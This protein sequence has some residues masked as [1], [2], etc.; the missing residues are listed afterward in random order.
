MLRNTDIRNDDAL[1]FSSFSIEINVFET[2]FYYLSHAYLCINVLSR[3]HFAAYVSILICMLTPHLPIS[4]LLFV[5]YTMRILMS[6][7]ANRVFLGSEFLCVNLFTNTMYLSS[8]FQT[9]RLP[10]R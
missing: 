4:V 8:V 1:N 3:N 9:V 6:A 5:S 10:P 7:N 2:L